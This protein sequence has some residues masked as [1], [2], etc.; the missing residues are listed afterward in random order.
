MNSLRQHMNSLRQR[1]FWKLLVS[2]LLIVFAGSAMLLTVAEWHMPVAIQRHAL[3]MQA[4]LGIEDPNIVATVQRDFR[5][6]IEEVLRVASIVASF[7]A[8]GISFFVS[9]RIVNPIEAIE[10]ATREIAAGNY[11]QRVPIYSE[12]ELGGL[13]QS[14]NRM[15][16]T[17]ESTEQRRMMLIGDVSHELRTPLTNIRSILEGLSDGVFSLTPEMLALMTREVQRMERLIHDLHELSRAEA[18]Q[19]HLEFQPVHIETILR[20][21]CERL[22]P[23]FQAKEVEL[24]YEPLPSLPPMCADPQ[25]LMQV[26]TNIIGNAL[27]YTPAGGRVW[28]RLHR[29]ATHVQIEV[30]DTGIGIPAEHLPHIFERFYRVDK[31]RSRMSGGSGIGLTISQ[32]LVE[33][34]GGHITAHSQG[35]GHGSTFRIEL[36]LRQ[37]PCPSS[38]N[39]QMNFTK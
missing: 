23:Q 34:H 25:R 22:E 16:E 12:D 15:A 3:Q 4:R 8:I 19:I 18:G 38:Q 26:F 37:P 2:Y 29:T 33:L 17:L 9:R 39:L 7:V 13:A 1:L 10:R 6:A 28:V 27:Q 30:Q 14:F 36:P 21:T 20:E 31:S 35:V 5:D 32:H 11:E 24:L